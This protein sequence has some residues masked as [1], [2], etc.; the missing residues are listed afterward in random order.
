NETRERPSRRTAGTRTA[1]G[2]TQEPQPMNRLQWSLRVLVVST[3]A[4]VG[5]QAHA[6]ET[7]GAGV[8]GV[9]PAPP[10]WL[11]GEKGNLAIASD[12]G[13]TISNTSQT[14]R[15]GSTTT[16]EL[17]PAVDYF[18]VDNMSIGGFIGFDYT[19]VPTGHTTSFSIGPRFGY[20]IVF[21][22]LFSVWPKIGLSFSHVN[23]ATDTAPS[24]TTNNLTFNLFVPLMLHPAPHF[25]LGF[26]PALD[27]DLTGSV[28]TTVIAGRLTIGGWI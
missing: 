6:Q 18:I 10:A 20:D 5:E 17:R 19:H 16:I 14:G 26:G 2:E 4:L 12:A 27:T 21:A 28:N 1:L 9:R 11:F 15:G 25:F 7:V 13:L 8:R 23:G 24:V 22:P 3:L